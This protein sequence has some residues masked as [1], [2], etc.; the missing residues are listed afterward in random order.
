M[1]VCEDQPGD[2]TFSEGRSGSMIFYEDQP[3]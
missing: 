1:I 2:T 3:D